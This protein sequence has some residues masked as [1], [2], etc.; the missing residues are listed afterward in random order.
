VLEDLVDDMLRAEEAK[1][2]SVA[3]GD[4]HGPLVVGACIQDVLAEP[5]GV[6]QYRWREEEVGGKDARLDGEPDRLYRA[7]DMWRVIL[8]PAA[9]YRFLGRSE[10]LCIDA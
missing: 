8:R 5:I 9:P 6:G 10:M 1:Q 3:G 4:E 7:S 2:S